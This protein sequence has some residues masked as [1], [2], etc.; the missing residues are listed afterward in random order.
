MGPTTLVRL[1]RSK[2]GLDNLRKLQIDWSKMFFVFVR[3]FTHDST[4]KL[5]KDGGHFV[6][7]RCTMDL[8]VNEEIE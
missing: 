4:S 1:D 8:V 2:A 7:I 5:T 6:R 3:Y